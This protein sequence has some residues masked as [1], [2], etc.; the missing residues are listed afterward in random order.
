MNK[1]LK[2]LQFVKELPHANGGPVGIYTNKWDI[3]EKEL[4]QA[5]ENEKLLNVFKNALTIERKPINN[6][7]SFKKDREDCISSLASEII[8]IKQNELNEKLRKSL[9]EWVLK[10]AFPKELKR[11]EE[12]EKAFNSLSKDHE[13]AMKELSKEIEKYKELRIIKDKQYY[14]LSTISDIIR[15]FNKGEFA[16]AEIALQEITCM[17][18]EVLLWV[19]WEKLLQN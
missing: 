3:I 4:K 14:A 16:S 9:R 10:N 19:E 8:E 13:K 7:Y 15:D 5:E 12:L 6:I 1:G 2:A 11:L 18:K 17:L